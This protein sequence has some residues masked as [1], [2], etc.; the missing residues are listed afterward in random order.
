VTTDVPG[1]FAAGASTGPADLEDTVTSAGSAAMKA[2]AFVM[3]AAR[4]AA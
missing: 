3:R 1:I 2:A 4:G